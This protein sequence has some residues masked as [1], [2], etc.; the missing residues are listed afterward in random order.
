MDSIQTNSLFNVKGLVAVITGGGSGIGLMAAKALDINGAK[1]VYIIGRR[2]EKLEAAAKEAVNGS[3]KPLVGDA[4]N[5]DSLAA[6][7]KQ[8][9]AETGYINLLLANAGLFGVQINDKLPAGRHP[10][11]QEFRDV[12]WEPSMEDFDRVYHMN[13]TG[14]FYTTVAFLG[15]LDAGNSKRVAKNTTSQVIVTASIGGFL[16]EPTDGWAYTTS[17]AGALH[18]VKMMSTYFG[19]WKIRANAIA[20]GIFPSEQTTTLPILQT[21]NDVTEEGSLPSDLIPAGRS[22]APEDIAGVILYLASRAGGYINGTTIMADGGR[23]G[24]LHASF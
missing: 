20:P 2:R 19:P 21:D 8:V 1:A 14:V 16:R 10:T 6:M 15:L 23:L 17:K 7:A 12:A 24:Q 18:M 11:V 5:K 9:E 13:L 22:G 3:L 4:A